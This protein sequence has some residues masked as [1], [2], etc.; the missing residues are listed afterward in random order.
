MLT[1]IALIHV[2]H[3]HHRQFNVLLVYL[4]LILQIIRISPMIILVYLNAH[5]IIIQMGHNVLN[6]L[7]IAL[8][9]KDLQYIAY[10]V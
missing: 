3:V 6:V 10:R 9:A 5:Q 8:T 1:H 4:Y 2:P 7:I